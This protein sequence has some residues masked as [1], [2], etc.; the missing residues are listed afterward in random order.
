MPREYKYDLSIVVPC[1]N[2]EKV[3][4]LTMPPL[5]DAF[6]KADVR[7]QLILVDN[8]SK[9]DTCAI[10]DRL[11]ERGLP[12]TKGIVPVNRGQ[13]LGYLAGF[14]LAEGQFVCNLCADGQ[15]QPADVLRVYQAAAQAKAPT[16]AKARR[17]FR[18]DSWVRKIISIIYNGMMLVIF[19]GMGTLDVNGNPK[20]LPAEILRQMELV[21]IDWFL[22]AELMLKARE[23][24]L[25]VIEV[26]VPGQLRRAGRSHVRG[27]A[28]IEFLKNMARYRFGSALTDWRKRHR[29]QLPTPEA[30]SKLS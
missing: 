12:V 17:R 6:Q 1:Y 16:L 13:G 3:L 9:D 25:P 30:L 21:S 15:V 4:D 5:V 10:I 7:L 18:Q 28:L 23:L 22:E 26:D 29:A 8:G 20:T 27:D 11:I 14:D 19:P 2:E 24:R